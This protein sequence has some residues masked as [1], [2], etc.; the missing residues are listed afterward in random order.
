MSKLRIHVVVFG[1]GNVGGTLINQVI[2]KQKYFFE[3]RNIDLRFPIIANSSLALFEKG[4][5]KNTWETDFKTS[6]IPF[7]I[8]DVVE[9]AKIHCLENLIA[10]D[11][12][13]S[14]NLIN[15]YIPLIQNGFNIVAANKTANTL[16]IDF[17]NELRK[18]LKKQDKTFLYETSIGTGFPVL[19]TLRDLHYS[20]EK[21]T[22]IRGVLSPSL[23]YVF[24]RF[25]SEDNSFSSIVSE[26]EKLGLSK[27]D[28]KGDLSGKDTAEKLLILAREIG[29]NIE[30]SDIKVT[31]LLLENDTDFN[32][33]HKLHF[34]DIIP[35]NAFKIAKN[36]Q[37]ES[38]VLRY[39]GEFSVLE[40][41]L[42]VKLTSEPISSPTGQLKDLE[43]NLE[44]YTESYGKIPIVIQGGG[45]GKQI[46]ARGILTDI[47]KVAE[48]IK[49]KEMV[50][51]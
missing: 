2:E 12:T 51:A 23:S 31:S 11:A 17:Y 35:D 50:L 37:A 6:A 49:T 39:V 5:V 26:A 21:I 43:T 44:I 8:E 48:R 19:Q 45:V 22:K 28:V 25:S 14:A 3:K 38:Y 27:L 29:E 30:Y 13:E 42:E 10:V 7:D 41:K 36:A 16:G 20:E 32:S 33:K 40:N 9:Y 47:L 1:I 46:V 34:S 24:N 18:N 4:G 15:H